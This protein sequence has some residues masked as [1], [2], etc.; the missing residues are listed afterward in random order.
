MRR[1]AEAQVQELP[2]EELAHLAA[3]ARGVNYYIWERAS[4]L[5]VEFVL[6][7]YEPR[8]WTIADSLVIALSMDRTLTE[9]WETDIGEVETSAR[10]F[11]GTS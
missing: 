8:P 10:R 6:M 5:P 1:I 3:Y 7:G 11:P 4:A 2:P 9:S